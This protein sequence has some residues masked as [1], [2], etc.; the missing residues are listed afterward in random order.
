MRN[1]SETLTRRTIVLQPSGIRRFFDIARTMGDIIPLGVGGP[2]SDMPWPIRE[3]DIYPLECGHIFYMSNADLNELHEEIVRYIQCRFDI[4]YEPLNKVTVTVDGS[5]SID[6]TCR[7]VL[8]PGGEVITPQPSY[9]SYEPCVRLMDDVP[10]IVGLKEKDCFKLM[11]EGLEKATA[12]RTKLLVLPFPNN[13][14]GS[15][16]IGEESAAIAE[17]TIRYDLYM[18]SDEIYTEFTHDGEAPAS[19]IQI[20]SM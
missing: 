4:P 15:I 20:P 11:P 3:G 10:I 19:I 9:A 14:A 7:A 16:M 8:D 12:P 18:V 17:I 2:D 5:K 1:I 6:L 13:S